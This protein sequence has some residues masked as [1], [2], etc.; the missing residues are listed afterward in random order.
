M[1][2]PT[3]PPDYI[4]IVEYRDSGCTELVRSEQPI[5]EADVV[6]HAIIFFRCEPRFEQVQLGEQVRVSGP[7]RLAGQPRPIS[8]LDLARAEQL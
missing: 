1:T 4:Y 3:F 8:D 6:A 2:Q 7:F 5:S